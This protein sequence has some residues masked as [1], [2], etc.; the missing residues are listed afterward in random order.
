M[1]MYSKSVDYSNKMLAERI[2][3]GRLLDVGGSDFVG[4]ANHLAPLVEEV[5]IADPAPPRG[6]LARNVVHSLTPVEA[7][8]SALGSFTN[9]L[10]SNVLE[11]LAAPPLAVGKVWERLSPGGSLHVLSPN[12]ESLNRRI[13]R[14]MGILKDLKEITPQEAAL[15]HRHAFTVA[16]VI[17]FL[18]NAGFVV[19]EVQGVFLKPLPTDEM[20]AWPEPRIEAFFTVASQLP[21]E[22]CHEVYFRAVKG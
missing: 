10:L 22:I 7:I 13:G 21:P 5:V 8:S 11:H 12:C 2:R 4:R 14:L 16:D 18:T 15:G 9:V 6:S 1:R 19:A 20:I 17:D 3:G